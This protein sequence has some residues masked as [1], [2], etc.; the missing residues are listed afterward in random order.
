MGDAGSDDGPRVGHPGNGRPNVQRHHDQCQRRRRDGVARGLRC[1]GGCGRREFAAHDLGTA[2]AHRHTVRSIRVPTERHRPGRRRVDVH[3]YGQTSLGYVRP[4]DWAARGH[5]RSRRCGR[6]ARC[7]DS[8]ERRC[9]DNGAADVLDP[10]LRARRAGLRG[11]E[12]DKR[13]ASDQRY[14]VAV[15]ACRRG[16]LV[17]ARRE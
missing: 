10:N 3:D 6:R 13:A 5:S 2:R 1:R 4:G 12:P 8:R 9:R 14:A 11:A 7:R 15:R 17:H 16:V